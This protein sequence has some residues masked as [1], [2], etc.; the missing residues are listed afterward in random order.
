MAKE[1]DIDRK[2]AISRFRNGMWA[3]E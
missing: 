3:L 1:T 2:Q